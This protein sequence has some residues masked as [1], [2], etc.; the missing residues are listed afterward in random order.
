MQYTQLLNCFQNHFNSSRLNDSTRWVPTMDL[1]TILVTLKRSYNCVI[2]Q[3]ITHNS[4]HTISQYTCISQ[5]IT[6]SHFQSQFHDPNIIIYHANPV[7]SCPKYKQ[8]IQKILLTT[9]GV[10]PLK[11]FHINISKSKKELQYNK[12]PK[13]SSNLIL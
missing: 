6:Y 8:I 4:I 9:G 7:K 12:H 10:K 3:F 2:E 1:I 13:M 11:Q 5:F